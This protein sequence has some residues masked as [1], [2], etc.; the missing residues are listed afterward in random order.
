MV[1][2]V[3]IEVFISYIVSDWVAGEE[4][5]EGGMVEAVAVEEETGFWVEELGGKGASPVIIGG[6]ARC[7]GRGV[8]LAGAEGGVGV[9][10]EWGGGGVGEGN[11]VPVGVGERVSGMVVDVAADEVVDVTETPGVMDARLVVSGF[12]EALPFVVIVIAASFG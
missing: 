1:R 7:E 9:A 8:N 4:A 2:N 6:G 12:K 5:A 3:P 10:F 11:D